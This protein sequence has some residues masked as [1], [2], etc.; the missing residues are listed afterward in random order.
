MTSWIL[1]LTILTSGHGAALT[2]VPGFTA[3]QDCVAAAAEWLRAMNAQPGGFRYYS[4][5]CLP[6]KRA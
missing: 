1:V 3:Q 4:A 2:N 6:Q 5:I